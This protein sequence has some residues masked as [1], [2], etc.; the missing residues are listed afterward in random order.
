[1]LIGISVTSKKDK[2]SPTVNALTLG[3]IL[4]QVCRLHHFRAHTLFEAIGVYRGQPPVLEALWQNDGLTHS[5]LAA[6]LNIRPA[7]VS[8]MVQRMEQAGFLERRPDPTDQRVSRV[9]LTRE[10]V[11]IRV[12]LQ[13]AIRTI[14]TDTFAGF[15]PE[16]CIQA[17]KMLSRIRDNL[18]QANKMEKMP[19]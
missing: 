19:Q 7:T 6:Q 8:R 9:Y 5:E 3:P 13:R 12:A 1:V 2:S 15:T 16:E 18:L 17:E 11:K 10:G 14:D 4:V